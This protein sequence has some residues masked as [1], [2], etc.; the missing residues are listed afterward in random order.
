MI[1]LRIS[2][3]P[4]ASLSDDEFQI[5]RIRPGLS[6]EASGLVHQWDD[7]AG[8]SFYLLGHIVGVRLADQSLAHPSLVKLETHRLQDPGRIPEIEGRFVVLKVTAENVC[9]VWTDR[10][11]RVE[12]YWQ[13]DGNSVVLATSLDLLPI[14][15]NARSTPNNIGVAHALTVY[16]SRPAK[17]H[18]L[19]RDVRRLGV[20][21]GIQMRGGET[22]L[23]HRSFLPLNTEPAFMEKDLHRYA[24][25]FLEAIRARASNSG[26]V[27]YLSSGWDSTS[28]LAA[29]V[30]LVGNRKTRAI[31][32][33]MRYS[34]RSGVIN[35]F[36]LDRALAVARYF[37]VRLDVVE[38]DYRNCAADILDEISPS[39][40]SQQFGNLTGMNHW[41]LAK[42]AAR[43]SGGDEVVFAGE[44]SDGAHNL[45]FS[46]FVSIFHPA[47]LEFREY[48]DKMASYLFGPTFFKQ[49]QSGCHED[50]PV[51][52]LFR[53]R[54]TIS[55]FD[56]PAVGTKNIAKQF[57]SSFFLRSGRMPMYSL[58]NSRLLTPEGRDQYALESEKVYLDG[59]VD[60]VNGDTLYAHYLHLY[61]SFHW[62]GA[63]VSTLEHTAEVHGL[64]CALPFHDSAVIEFLSAMPETWG[65]GLDLNPTKYPLKWMLRNRI[66]YPNHL[67]IGP[68]SYTYDVDPSFSLLGEILYAS[69]FKPVFTSA[70]KKGNFVDWLEPQVFDHL[71]VDNLVAKYLAG[72]ILFGQEMSDLGVLAMHSAIGVYGS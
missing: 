58:E 19:Y 57:L 27:V 65:R 21:Q 23:L 35:Q 62:Q 66:D 26:N 63:T 10:Y 6:I 9:E 16:G 44:M 3:G 38:L 7:A 60:G 55:K 33:R 47:S 15:G 64:R 22:E 28:I 42:F 50:D 53:Q 59:L 40:R 20:D 34:D 48:G 25:S 12:I 68:H 56:S 72:E 31:I 1:K 69:S 61:N 29:L 71:Y 17:Q 45:G 46:Q 13:R 39:F 18:T 14:A 5:K 67:Q 41:L 54:A 51:W 4:A 36:E 8:S 43:T 49:V 37:D 70:L 30:H 52:Q 2:S 11:G 24:D 32:G